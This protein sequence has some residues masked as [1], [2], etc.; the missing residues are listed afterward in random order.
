MILDNNIRR[1]ESVQNLQN[2]MMRASDASESSN[3]IIQHQNNFE[4][5]L[6]NFDKTISSNHKDQ[7]EIKDRL[8]QDRPRF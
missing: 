2:T 6:D 8:S 4:N 7:K 5:M 1:N 3:E